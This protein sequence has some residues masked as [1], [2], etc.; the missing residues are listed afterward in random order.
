MTATS[1]NETLRLA[2]L[3]SGG[4]R[5][6]NNIAESIQ[7]GE[8]N[9]EIAVVISSRPDAYG[10]VRAQ[11]LQL[12]TQTVPRAAYKD[13]NEFSDV[14]WQNIHAASAQLIVLAG[15]LSLLV[16][17]KDYRDKVINIHPALLPSFGGHRMYGRRVHEAVLDSGC[18]ISGCTVH[19]ADASYDTGPI[20][21]QCTCPVLEDDTPETLAGRVFALECKAYPEAINLIASNRVAVEGRRTRVVTRPSV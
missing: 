13:D 6:L 3:L 18:K 19:F 14:V 9:A 15:F 2:V 5:T 4:G 12:P 7:R 1:P 21:M 16:I 8:L 17:P 10:L 11:N 20:I